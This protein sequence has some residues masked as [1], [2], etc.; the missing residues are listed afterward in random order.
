MKT[1]KQVQAENEHCTVFTLKQFE[2]HLDDRTIIPY[3]GTGYFHDG[4]KE[5]KVCVWDDN[6]TWDD[7]KKYPYVCW[8]NR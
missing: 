5:T 1:R 3:D 6:L 2:K 8:Y 4:E 7:V